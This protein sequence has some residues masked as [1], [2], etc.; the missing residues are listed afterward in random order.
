MKRR[1]LEWVVK[2]LNAWLITALLVLP[3]PAFAQTYLLMAEEA[4]CA[5]CARWNEEI[6]HI[7]PKT[8]EGR[9]APLQRYDL[10]GAAP[11]VDFA[12]KVRFTPTFILIHDGTEVGRIE[13]YPGEDFFWSLLTMMFERAGIP[14]D[15]TD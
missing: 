9:T 10:H 14:L 12:Q 4:G 13:G 2:T 6:S 1:Q 3:L 15:N 8:A 7:Y 5:W 11:D